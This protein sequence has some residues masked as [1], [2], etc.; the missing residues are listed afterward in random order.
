MQPVYMTLHDSVALYGLAWRPLL[1]E[2][3]A[4]QLPC[5]VLQGM[6]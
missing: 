2:H 1:L 6:I 3:L 5:T 4:H